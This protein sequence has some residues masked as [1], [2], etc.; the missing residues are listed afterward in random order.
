MTASSAAPSAVAA[1]TR[2]CPWW[3]TL[4]I[5]IAAVVVGAT[6][7]WGTTETRVQTYIFLVKGLGLT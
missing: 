2:Q 5:G 7:L 1:P 3:L 4:I 6:M